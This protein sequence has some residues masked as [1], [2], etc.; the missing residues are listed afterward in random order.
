MDVEGVGG[1]GVKKKSAHCLEGK[2]LVQP[3]STC[4][5]TLMWFTCCHL[6][7]FFPD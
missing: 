5:D 1:G 2:T 4:G 3:A 7:C 6:R